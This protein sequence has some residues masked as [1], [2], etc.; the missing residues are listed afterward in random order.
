MPSSFTR[1]LTVTKI[2][3]RQ[4]RV[5][6]QF[7]YFIGSEDSDEFITVP[8][9]FITDFASVPRL[10]WIFIPPDGKYTQACVLHDYLYHKQL[11]S[12]KESDT[13]FLEAMKVSKVFWLK[14]RIIY[15]AV[16]LFGWMCWK[17][18]NNET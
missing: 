9:G 2:D 3:A 11:Y 7:I 12:R 10:F 14:R 18:R 15:R 6:R 4:W 5:E 16:R 13:I 8:K 1:P 17:K